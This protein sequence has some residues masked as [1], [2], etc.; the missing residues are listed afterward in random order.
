NMVAIDNM[1]PQQVG[2]KHI[3]SSYIE[4]RKSVITKRS[5]YE[6][7]KAKKRQHIVEGLM[8]ALSILDEVITEIRNSKDKKDAKN[9]L[10]ARF[11]F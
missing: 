1:T 10:V 5:Q 3:L 7:A 8:K 6:L 11:D 4:H 2:L 9:N